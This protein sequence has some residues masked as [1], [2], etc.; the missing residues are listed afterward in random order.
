MPV[1]S[2]TSLEKLN[3]VHSDLQILFKTVVQYF[4][5]SVVSGLRTGLYTGAGGDTK[6]T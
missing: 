3:T 4:D 5:C 1:F 2:Q 6:K